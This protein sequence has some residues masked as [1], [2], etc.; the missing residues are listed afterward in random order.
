M[1]AQIKPNT[2]EAIRETDYHTPAGASE[3]FA[4]YARQITHPGFNL[5]NQ[6]K[7]AR[8]RVVIAG[9]GGLGGNVAWHLASAGIGK[10]ILVHA[11][12]LELPDLNRQTLMKDKWIGSSRVKRAAETLRAFNPQT[13]I[14]TFDEWIEEDN[15]IRIMENADLVIDARH[16]FKERK[17]LAKAAVQTGIPLVE[18]AMNGMEGY[19]FT[20]IPGKSACL[21]CVYPEAPEWDPFGFSVFGAVSGTIGSLAAMEAIKVLTSYEENLSGKMMW[22]DFTTFETSIYK[23]H[24]QENCPICGGL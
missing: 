5:E 18:A 1:A 4:R 12:E 17:A 3:S 2:K 8:A 14:L 10:L 16:N 19:L 9:I 7:L 22:V 11:G 20:T 24:R 13:E 21:S 15:A 6:V 23:L